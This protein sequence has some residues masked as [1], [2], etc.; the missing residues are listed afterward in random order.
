MMNK[1]A[2]YRGIGKGNNITKEPGY[3][4]MDEQGISIVNE[5]KQV[6]KVYSADYIDGQNNENNGDIKNIYAR[7]A[8]LE[9]KVSGLKKTNT[10][11][12]SV[13]N[14]N[15]NL[16]DAN[17][18]YIISGEMDKT[19]AITGKSLQMKDMDIT[20]PANA[21][22]TNG[23]AVLIN[24]SQDVQ[25]K[26]S[27]IQMNQGTSSNCIKVTNADTLIIKDTTF[28]GTT[29]NT[30][31]T[32]QNS[33]GFIK[34]MLIDNCDFNE[35]C[36]HINIWFAGHADNAVL[37]ISNCHFK[38]C[39]QFLCISDFADA[40]NKLTVNIINCTIDNYDNSYISGHG[41]E[42][43]GIILIE[44]RNI[45]DINA[46]REKNPYGNGKLI[47]N[48]NNLTVKGQKITEDNFK[49]ANKEQDQMLYYYHKQSGCLPYDEELF[50]VITIK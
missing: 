34:N 33:T 36:K 13:Q 35:D 17:K 2:R 18:D 32:G 49:V 28:T 1:V 11:V 25:I 39:E 43:A 15:M 37:T 7:L 29:Y 26:G 5:L 46:L 31:M 3:I 47:I 6:K 12:I 45:G 48:I 27:E 42:Y 23:N 22:L 41:Y 21:N 16:N 30:I 8:I 38:T 50:P 24:A 19:G 9:D 40:D 14:D 10:Q 4:Y 20:L 44:S